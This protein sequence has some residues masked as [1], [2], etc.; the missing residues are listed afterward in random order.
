MTTEEIKPEDVED[1]IG[2]PIF[3]PLDLKHTS[4]TKQVATTNR[5]QSILDNTYIKWLVIGLSVSVIILVI[6]LY[7]RKIKAAKRQVEADDDDEEEANDDNSLESENERLK[8]EVQQLQLSNQSYVN[9]IN[10]LADQLEQ[11]QHSKSNPYSPV[12]PMTSDSYEAPDPEAPKEKPQVVKDKELIKQM[13]NSP[14]PTVQDE[15]DKKQAKEDEDNAEKEQQAIN[16]IKETTQVEDDDNNEEEDD[17][18]DVQ[19]L[20]NIIQSQ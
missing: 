9:H 17:G 5:A 18:K 19:A 6:I 14:R 13:V 10:R 2:S 1:L 8:Q 15:L 4:E 16:D 7:Y 3:N 11:Q 20:M 12:L